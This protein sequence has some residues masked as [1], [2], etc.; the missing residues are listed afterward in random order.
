[1]NRVLQTAGDVLVGLGLALLT[2]AA[3]FAVL[4]VDAAGGGR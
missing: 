3:V 1:M 2:G 4:L